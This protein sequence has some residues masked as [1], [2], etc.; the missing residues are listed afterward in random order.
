MKSQTQKGTRPI[1]L[2][3]DQG[4]FHYTRSKESVKILIL[5]FAGRRTGQQVSGWVLTRTRRLV[6]SG[7]RTRHVDQRGSDC[8]GRA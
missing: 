6:G 1:L 3:S 2:E 8:Q 5:D 4:E 7:P